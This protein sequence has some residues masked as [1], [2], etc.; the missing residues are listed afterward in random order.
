M[1][2]VLGIDPGL[3]DTG[4]AVIESQ[5]GKK[6]VLN[7]FGLIKTPSSLALSKRLKKIYDSIIDIIKQH[8]INSAAI[9]EAYFID[10]IKTQS[11][12]LHAR[13]V[14][15]LAFEN[16]LIKYNEYNPK[17]VKKMITGNGNANK[18]QVEA[19][20]KMIF[21]IREKLYPDIADAIAIALA[22]TRI[23]KL[24]EKNI[25]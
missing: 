18:V 17:M 19:V 7:E 11:L 12:T 9:E 14:I 6:V 25:L 21:S 2:K 4:W 3:E 20:V 1:R 22:D 13:G 5:K 16:S 23:Y 10:K 15:L 8:S 24:K